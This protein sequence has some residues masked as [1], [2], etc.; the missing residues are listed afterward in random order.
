[1][2]LASRTHDQPLENLTTPFSIAETSS[3]I[4]RPPSTKHPCAHC[5]Q[6]SGKVAVISAP[7][8]A[9][10]PEGPHSSSGLRSIHFPLMLIKLLA[11]AGAAS[12]ALF[13]LRHVHPFLNSRTPG[14]TNLPTQDSSPSCRSSNLT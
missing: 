9:I 6:F 4:V 3:K 10:D 14:S 7:S 1:M 2:A 11:S 13:L 5:H 12:S 8:C